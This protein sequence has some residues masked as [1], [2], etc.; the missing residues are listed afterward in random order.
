LKDNIILNKEFLTVDKL[1]NKLKSYPKNSLILVDGYEDGMD[2]VLDIKNI[3]V[4]YDDSRKWYYGPFEEVTDSK[5]EA[6][7]LISTRGTRV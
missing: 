4:K 3:K 6:I 1:I 5:L 2:A 7:K